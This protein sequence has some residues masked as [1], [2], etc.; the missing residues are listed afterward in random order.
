LTFNFIIAAWI[1]ERFEKQ[2][3]HLIEAEPLPLHIQAKPLLIWSIVFAFV[4]W[5]VSWK[6]DLA[7][8]TA[9][10]YVFLMGT[11]SLSVNRILIDWEDNQPGGWNYPE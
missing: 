8:F 4:A 2:N 3:P 5:G 7:Y 9:F 6:W 1:G 11:T 10:A